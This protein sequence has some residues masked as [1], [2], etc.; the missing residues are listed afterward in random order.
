MK[1]LQIVPR[2]NVPSFVRNLWQTD[3]FKEA[4]DDF[5]SFVHDMVVRL[6]KYPRTFFTPTEDIE[7]GHFTTWMGFISL[8]DHY[9]NPYIHDLYLLHELTHLSTM[10]YFPGKVD[11]DTWYL[12]MQE[13]ELHSALASEVFIYFFMMQEG[14]DIRHKTFEHEIWADRFSH[15][16]TTG[17]GVNLSNYLEK[18]EQIVSARRTVMHGFG[19]NPDASPDNPKEWA[20]YQISRFAKQ[21]YEW[22]T[23]W[24]ENYRIVENGM[25]HMMEQ[26]DKVGIYV[27]K[28]EEIF[29]NYQRWYLT[30]FHEKAIYFRDE[31]VAFDEMFKRNNSVFGNLTTGKQQTV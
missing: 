12:K 6:A 4:H 29:G 25:F 7:H 14:R 1:D 16:W 26:I 13:N 17:I 11:F 3:E 15:L 10:P 20:A 18:F 21:N 30:R 8:R 27:G 23:V 31:A 9:T 19:V 2:C 22:A 5:G 24:R 28:D